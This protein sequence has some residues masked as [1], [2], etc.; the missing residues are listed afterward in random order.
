MAEAS[1]ECTER[2]KITD[3]SIAADPVAG[4]PSPDRVRLSDG[5]HYARLLLYRVPETLIPNYTNMC[6][7]SMQVALQ[8]YG[9][10]RREALKCSEMNEAK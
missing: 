8:R 7:I 9:C 10:T 3:C 1:E 5:D 4:D 6:D 2:V